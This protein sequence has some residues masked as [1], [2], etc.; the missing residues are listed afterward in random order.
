MV[1]NS[2]YS[3]G[4]AQSFTT[5]F[6]DNH[7][8]RVLHEINRIEVT[9]L[10]DQRTPCQPI[11]RKLDM[12]TCIQKY[13]ETKI[14]CQLPWHSDQTTLSKCIEA[15]QYREFLTSYE[16]IAGLSGFSMAQ[17][18]GCYPSCKINKFSVTVIDHVKGQNAWYFAG[19]FFYPGGQYKKKLYHLT[20]DF[21]SYIADAGGLVG[22]FL[23][24]SMLSIYDKL[25]N[26]WKNKRI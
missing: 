2:L 10:N 19:Y 17:R 22:L 9:Y 12:N 7:S 15:E 20:Y 26:A 5:H 14:K 13:I 23:G 16:E 24:F 21:T 6:N 3:F 8:L 11:R 18:T 25:R 4:S 1:H